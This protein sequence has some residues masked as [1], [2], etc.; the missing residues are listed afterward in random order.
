M[1]W[2]TGLAAVPSQWTCPGS[3]K[4]KEILEN[5]SKSHRMQ[6][7]EFSNEEKTSSLHGII[8]NGEKNTFPWLFN[9][10][11]PER[12][13]RCILYL[14]PNGA[15]ISAWFSSKSQ[16]ISEDLYKIGGVPR[17]LYE[18][19]E[20]PI[21]M[22]DYEGT[23]L[24]REPLSWNKFYFPTC[25][26]VVADGETATQYAASRCDLVDIV[27]SSLGGGVATVALDRYLQ[28]FPDHKQRFRLF[29]HD[30]FS[31]TAKV[32]LPIFPTI[33][34]WLAWA[35]GGLLDAESAMS[36]LVRREIPITVLYNQHDHVIPKGA[37]MA[38][39]INHLEDKKNI[40][41]IQEK[42]DHGHSD[43]TMWMRMGL[44]CAKDPF[45]LAK[46][47][48]K[49]RTNEYCRQFDEPSTPT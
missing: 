30:S 18:I 5:A 46:D 33:A 9:D 38:E 35:V 10:S 4:S 45:S 31:T 19:G 37:Q 40:Y 21:I 23:G 2:I 49:I 8:Y 20:I 48:K 39:W 17:D 12:L 7:V 13:P 22:Y 28:K 24:N 16:Q 25:E 15:T 44:S 29:N 42:L 41:L 27:G 14:N 3:E 1:A 32:V 34:N 47:P 6:F 43:L 11:L 36:S 26:S